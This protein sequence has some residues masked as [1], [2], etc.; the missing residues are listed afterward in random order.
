MTLRDVIRNA[1]EQR[2][3]ALA[4]AWRSLRD[5]L[6]LARLR[7]QRTAHGFL[8]AGDR[9]M[10]DGTFEPDE[11][12]IVRELLQRADRLIDV[13]ANAGYYT[14]IA[15]ASGRSAIAIEPS[16]ANCRLLMHNLARNHWDDVEIWPM[17][18]AAKPGLLPLYGAA[19]GATL[20]AGWNGIS[21]Q[22]RQ[23]VPVTTL[24][25]LIGDR[26]AG[27]RL[28]VK[29]DVEGAEYDVLAGATK[30]A[31]RSPKPFWMIEATYTLHAGPT[32]S[33]D[34]RFLNTFDYFW[35]RGYE[36]R[37]SHDQ[38][39]RVTREQLLEWMRQNALPTYNWF[40]AEQW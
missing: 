33:S 6:H 10:Q 14:A 15:R 21:A 23:L 32:G 31:M 8:F 4:R 37:A 2:T 39:T 12:R 30:T 18:V 3:P 40:F 28:L 11:T 36:C 19:T 35:S 25:T 27:E 16:P 24:D 20:V 9:S 29:I 5:E 38:R 1:V 34:A 17:A 22:Y 26:F 7:P 13:G